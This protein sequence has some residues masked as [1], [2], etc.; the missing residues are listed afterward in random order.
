MFSVFL[1]T[2]IYLLLNHYA[3]DSELNA[4][5]LKYEWKQGCIFSLGKYKLRVYV[6]DIKVGSVGKM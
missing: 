1:I 3:D 5:Q 6:K 2:Y 4:S